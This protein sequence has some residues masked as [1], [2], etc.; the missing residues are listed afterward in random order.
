MVV[1]DALRPVGVVGSEATCP[2]RQALD[3]IGDR[4]TL[5]VVKALVEGDKRYGTLHRSIEGISQK[6]LTQ[7]LRSMERDGLVRRSVY[8]V[9]PPRVEYSLTP[10]GQSLIGL[11]GAIGGWAEQH[12]DDVY[13]AREHHDAGLHHAGE[14]GI[15]S[16][17]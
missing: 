5:I 4:W 1:Q 3:L 9:V 12:M 17:P 8:P 16:I 13:R 6:M 2:S 10:L 11:L 14:P 7:T 15:T